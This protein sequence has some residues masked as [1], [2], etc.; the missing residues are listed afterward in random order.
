VLTLLARTRHV[1]GA[2]P[3]SQPRRVRAVARGYLQL[4]DAARARRT[5]AFVLVDAVLHSGIYTWLGVYFDRRYGLGEVGIGLAL[6]G[7]GLPGFA[8]GPRSGASP[9]GGDGPASSPSGLPW[10]ARRPPS[11]RRNSPSASPPSPSPCCPLA[12][13]SPKPLLAGIVTDL[14]T[15]R[16]Q[17]MGLNV[18]VLFTGFGLGSL[19][20]QSL[21]TVGFGAALML[22][23]ATAAV[24]SLLAVPAFAGEAPKPAVAPTAP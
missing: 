22:F 5:Y 10:P 15:N 14:S 11:W 3:A 8:L 4:L 2:R 23:A 24:A 16:G 9:T 6:L 17:A 18:C 19:L 12:T 1:L 21:L 13:T 20:F 7:Y